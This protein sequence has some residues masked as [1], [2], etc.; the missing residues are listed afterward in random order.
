LKRGEG[1]WRRECWKRRKG[2][3]VAAAMSPTAM[4]ALG[5]TLETLQRS[6]RERERVEC[7]CVAWTVVERGV[8]S[9][10]SVRR[11]EG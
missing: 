7:V 10:F 11:V 6:E 5:P 4:A 3:G 2:L 8:L 1:F 9:G